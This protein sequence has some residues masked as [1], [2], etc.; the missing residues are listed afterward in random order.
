MV[1]IGNTRIEERGN[2]LERLTVHSDSL[3]PYLDRLYANDWSFTTAWH[4]GI[5]VD[6]V[7]PLERS[8][9]ILELEPKK[10]KGSHLP[11]YCSVEEPAKEYFASNFSLEENVRYGCLIGNSVQT[12]SRVL[13]PV[14]YF[15]IQPY[16][17][18]IHISYEGHQFIIHKI[19]SQ[20]S[21]GE[22][23]SALE[24]VFATMNGITKKVI[25]SLR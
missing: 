18:K 14:A 20:H 24:E 22:Q 13:V 8:P 1:K 17:G 25:D 19:P 9:L 21:R 6:I 12:E 5:E 11:F 2:R 16:T 4:M 7:Q 15:Q 3:A 23:N 10:I